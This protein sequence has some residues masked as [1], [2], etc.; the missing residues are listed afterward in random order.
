M[1]PMCIAPLNPLALTEDTNSVHWDKE[2]KKYWI[3]N[4]IRNRNL[5][6]DFEIALPQFHL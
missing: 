2:Y 3:A 6:F 1:S 5:I 4:Q